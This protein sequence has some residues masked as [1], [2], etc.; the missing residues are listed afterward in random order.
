M[1]VGYVAATVP[2]R[3]V[4]VSDTT[5]FEVAMRELGD[6]LHWVALARLNGLTSPWII[7]E[8]TILI[9]PVLPSGQPTGIL[10]L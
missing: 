10:G 6:A 2:A 1:T 9:P 4:R 8:Q 7:G 3:G 5:L